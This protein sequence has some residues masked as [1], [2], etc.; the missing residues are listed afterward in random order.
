MI[1]YAFQFQLLALAATLATTLQFAHWQITNMKMSKKW[2]NFCQWQ[3]TKNFLF[4][5]LVNMS[6]YVE[7]SFD[8][9]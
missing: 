5:K 1:I 7:N 2:D 3:G 4:E 8:M 9:I 6:G